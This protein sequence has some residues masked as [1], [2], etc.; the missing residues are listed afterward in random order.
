MSDY[1][2]IRFRAEL[3]D[4]DLKLEDFLAKAE[5]AGVAF[6]TDNQLSYGD[7]PCFG[8]SIQYNGF[9]FSQV[10][11]ISIDNGHLAIGV[12]CQ[13]LFRGVDYED[14]QDD[15]TNFD[16][17][18]SFLASVTTSELGAVLGC[19]SGDYHEAQHAEPLVMCEDG[20]IRC[21]TTDAVY[22]SQW[23]DDRDC[24]GVVSDN[25]PTEIVS[26][27]FDGAEIRLPEQELLEALA[28]EFVS[29]RP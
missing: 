26:G 14:R 28:K 18:R 1:Y 24:K 3:R 16:V 20:Q 11:G 23:D 10:V 22:W 27:T 12:F 29:P 5:E 15:T 19:V 8:P 21:L 2:N 25:V 17:L 9:D 4:P 13:N 7:N 6:D